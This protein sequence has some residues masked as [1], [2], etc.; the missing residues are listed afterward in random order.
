MWVWRKRQTDPSYQ[1]PHGLDVCHRNDVT[2]E[3]YDCNPDNLWLGTHSDNMR[4]K[5][6]KGR[7]NHAF[8]DRNGR[9]TKP[10]NWPIGEKHHFRAFPELICR[11][12]KNGRAKLSWAQVN[13]IRALYAAGDVTQIALANCFGVTQSTIA[14]ITSGRIWAAEHQS[15]CP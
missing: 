7:G 1:I 8:G 12:E 9:R 3:L 6:L 11:G 4:D 15:G 14:A 13:E 5:M 2:P 10:Q